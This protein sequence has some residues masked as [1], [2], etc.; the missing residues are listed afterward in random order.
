MTFR[1]L[2]AH[3]AVTGCDARAKVVTAVMMDTFAFAMSIAYEKHTSLPNF[4]PSRLKAFS[5]PTTKQGIE[6]VRP[7]MKP[8]S[9]DF[10][11]GRT[12][13]NHRTCFPKHRTLKFG[14][15]TQRK[16]SSMP[17]GTQRYS[18]TKMVLPLRVW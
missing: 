10:G 15:R 3:S 17:E 5:A 8:S 9:H 7:D 1:L 6:T 13:S 14:L 18:R 12:G 4:A 2:C 16:L 11:N